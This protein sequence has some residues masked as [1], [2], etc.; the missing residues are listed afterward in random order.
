MTLSR[1]IAGAVFVIA[2]FSPPMLHAQS[3]TSFAV[4][5]SL[6]GGVGSGGEYHSTDVIT[7]RI[8]GSLTHQPAQ[9]VGKFLELAAEPLGSLEGDKLTCVPSSR[10]GCTPRFPDFSSVTLLAGVISGRTNGH[11]ELRAGLGGGIASFEHTRVGVLVGQADVA[12]FPIR[13][14]GIVLAGRSHIIPR[15]RGDHLTTRVILVGLRF[16]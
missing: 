8:A 5:L 2:V 1:L 12:F 14:A 7:A 9:G 10:G 13:H 4:D 6:G 3:R 15:F 11:V 16:R